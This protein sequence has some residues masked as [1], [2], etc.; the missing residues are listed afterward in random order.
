MFL[1]VRCRWSWVAT[2]RR[3][4]PVSPGMVEN[5][6]LSDRHYTINKTIQSMWLG[7]YHNLESW[8]ILMIHI[9][10]NILHHHWNAIQLLS[11][12]WTLVFDLY[13]ANE[14]V[15]ENDVILY[16]WFDIINWCC[17]LNLKSMTQDCGKRTLSES[18]GRVSG[19]KIY[20]GLIV[21]V[22]D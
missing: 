21:I 19:K 10:I 4:I 18:A 1:E 14:L 22:A 16:V 17:Y 15:C 13:F 7:D 20:E 9:F 8:N 6:R 3:L 5:I 12:R 11:T 2:P